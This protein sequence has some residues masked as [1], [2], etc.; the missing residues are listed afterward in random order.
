MRNV[1]S[2]SQNAKWWE[3]QLNSILIEVSDDITTTTTIWMIS[4][5]HVD[6]WASLNCLIGLNGWW[7]WLSKDIR[8]RAVINLFIHQ[9]NEDWGALPLSP[10]CC[11]W[12]YYKSKSWA[13]TKRRNRSTI[14]LWINVIQISNW[15]TEDLNNFIFALSVIVVE[16]KVKGGLLRLRK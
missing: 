12:F 6:E 7:W 8:F 2:R 15:F 3:N 11:L 14:W 5:S 16:N 4:G 10:C 1:W 13:N 9:Q